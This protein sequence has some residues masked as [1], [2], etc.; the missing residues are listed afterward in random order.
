MPNPDRE[1][2]VAAPGHGAVIPPHFTYMEEKIH[3]ERVTSSI[4]VHYRNQE[5]LYFRN[6]NNKFLS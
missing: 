5:Y 2:Y 1:I 6:W 3:S 4:H